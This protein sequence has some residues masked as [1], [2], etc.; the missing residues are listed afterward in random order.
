[1]S[2]REMKRWSG[3]SASALLALLA[4]LVALGCG[5]DSAQRKA[6]VDEPAGA[7]LAGT[8][9]IT[10]RLERP[11]SLSMDA[12]SLPR[13]VTGTVALLEDHDGPHSFE[14]LHGATHVGV[15]DADLHSLGLPPRDAGIIPGVAARIV[16]SATR[17]PA[18][19][20]RDSIY[21]VINPETPRHSLRL[22]GTF[23]GTAAS[24]EWIAESFLGGGGTFTLR[25]RT[26]TAVAGQRDPG[27]SP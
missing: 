23:D 12:K 9:E 22:S 8:W 11:L 18:A 5:G 4:L 7:G 27:R 16:M 1:M 19:G 25:R 6:A 26:T 2:A 20:Q 14:Q 13:S 24:G 10:L 21:I 17:S 3:R 15:Y